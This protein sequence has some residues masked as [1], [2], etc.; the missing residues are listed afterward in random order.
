MSVRLLSGVEDYTHALE[1][2]R[3]WVELAKEKQGRS[4]IEVERERFLDCQEYASIFANTLQS[5]VSTRENA[6]DLLV[7]EVDGRVRSIVQISLY[8]ESG[9]IEYLCADPSHILSSLNPNREK[10][11]STALMQYVETMVKT[12]GITHLSLNPTNAHGFYGSIG[13]S[14][15]ANGFNME[16]FL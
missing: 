7:Y 9:I 3:G 8:E 2:I 11:A 5:R 6:D 16:K 13:Y 12:K 1:E 15:N 14:M 10:G 4:S